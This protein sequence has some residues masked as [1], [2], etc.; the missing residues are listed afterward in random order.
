MVI[1]LDAETAGAP[2]DV[3]WFDECEPGSDVA[4]WLVDGDIVPVTEVVPAIQVSTV[5]PIRAELA[6]LAVVDELGAA[7]VAADELSELIASC[8]RVMSQ[9]RA[10][11]A[12]LV[13]ELASRPE[14]APAQPAA[15]YRSV[16]AESCA[17]LELT[18]PLALTSGQA[19]YLVNESVQ[20]VRDFP[21]THAA[22]AQGEIDER[23]AR[24]IMSEL[25]RHDSEIAA[26]V[27]A[28]VLGRAG[29]QN[30]DQLRRRLKGLVHRLAPQEAEESRARAA[31]D[32]CVR[33]SPAE[34][35][36]AWIEALMRAEDAA[37]VEAVLDSGEKAL[38]R[39][40]AD[41]GDARARTRDQRRADV[42][43]RLAWAALAAGRIDPAAAGTTASGDDAARSPLREAAAG[44]SLS[45]AHGRPVAVQVTVSLT[46]LAGL[47]EEPGDLDGYGPIPARVARELAAAGIW[48]WVGC[49]PVTGA[50][51]DHGR[52][53]YTPTRDLVD[54]VLL[55][56]RTCKAPGCA[57]PA[58]RCDLDH[59]HAYSAGGSTCAANLV[60]LC[61]KHHLIKHHGPFTVDQPE[62]GTLRWISPTGRT[63]V[64]GPARAAPTPDDPPF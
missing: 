55:R 35:G 34:N 19:E 17:A 60:A 44:L 48:Q 31:A 41:A 57:V 15:G 10:L 25:G 29:E 32:R 33:V 13:E 5:A 36:M 40:D 7:E 28:A 47:D 20:L 49:D 43:A 22:L 56:D 23:R 9:A 27:E 53:R 38:K 46:T 8:Q 1:M 58:V 6:A 51:L 30:T 37:A 61:R 3:S 63:I 52:T 21:A 14:L 64:S 24:L 11:Q 50:V 2:A 42:L 39:A 4:C 59:V 54:H 26:A 18:A 45:G 62:P 12:T 16:S